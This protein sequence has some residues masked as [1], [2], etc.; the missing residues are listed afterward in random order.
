MQYQIFEHIIDV[1]N[2]SIKTYG[3]VLYVDGCE[4][5]RIHDVTTDY[6]AICELV[7]MLNEKRVD[8]FDLAK[9]VENF[10][11]KN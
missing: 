4:A 7:V 3:I 5:M 6:N 8:P 11:N 2:E 1:E 10:I 9:L